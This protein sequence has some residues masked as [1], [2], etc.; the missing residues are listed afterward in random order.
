[1][2]SRRLDFIL[3]VEIGHKATRA[4]IDSVRGNIVSV[5]NRIG[6]GVYAG[7]V[8]GLFYG[9]AATLHVCHDPALAERQRRGLFRAVGSP[10]G[11]WGNSPNVK[12]GAAAPILT[13]TAPN[14]TFTYKRNYDKIDAAALNNGFFCLLTNTSKNGAEAL[15]IYR[16]KDVIEKG[17]DD[18]KNHIGMK[19]MHTH[20]TAATNG[21]LF[22]A[23]VALTAISEI[24]AKLRDMMKDRSW[25]KDS[26]IA[27]LEKIKVVMASGGRRLLNPITKTQRLIFD[28]FGLTHDDLKH[29][30]SAT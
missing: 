21:K 18:L 9:A 6:Q 11:S 2:A 30:V 8:R 13:S 25:S 24:Q 29:Y 4:A 22:L 16:G 1:M 7:S 10:P 14:G 27:E 19:R 26:L 20:T 3:G 23:F 28:A 5:R 17:F 12:P 15:D